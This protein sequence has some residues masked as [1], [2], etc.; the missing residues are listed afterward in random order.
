MDRLPDAD[1][2]LLAAAAPV[3]RRLAALVREQ[4]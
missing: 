1:R 2:A 3:L 4:A